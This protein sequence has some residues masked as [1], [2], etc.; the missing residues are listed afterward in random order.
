MPD[1]VTEAEISVGS[2][3]LLVRIDPSRAPGD[4]QSAV[5]ARGPEVSFGKLTLTAVVS[6]S[7]RVN[8]GT[9]SYTIHLNARAISAIR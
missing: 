7:T 6:G 8:I 1:G 3:N 5:T 4:F 9:L 2:M